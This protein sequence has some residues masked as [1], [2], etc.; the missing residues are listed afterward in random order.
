MK[1][2][3]LV[4]IYLSLFVSFISCTNSLG[5]K[6]EW[7]ATYKQEFVSNCKAEINK[8]KSL[9]KID[10][11]IVF[12]ICDCIAEKAEK[13]FAPLD[14]EEENSQP[15]MKIISTDCARDILIKN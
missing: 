1:K 2:Y 8:E 9:I 3:L 5:K 14:M 12:T 11:L 4:F 6:G 7:N 13:E 10:S 15:Q